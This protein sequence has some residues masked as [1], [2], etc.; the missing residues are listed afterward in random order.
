MRVLIKKESTGIFSRLISWKTHSPYVHAELLFSDGNRFAINANH[1]AMFYAPKF[2]K[3]TPGLD[4]DADEWDCFDLY[5]GNE[6]WVYDWCDLHVDAKYDWRGLVFCQVFPWGW[7]SKDKW[8]CSEMTIA[9]L[10]AGRFPAVKGMKPYQYSP[11]KFHAALLRACAPGMG[12]TQIKP[13][14]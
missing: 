8:F 14:L 9:A 7:E 11:A 12:A 10:Q 3:V 4:W 1:P 13:A 5:G 6:E 2:E